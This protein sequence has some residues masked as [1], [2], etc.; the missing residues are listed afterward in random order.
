M[1]ER[2]SKANLGLERSSSR[3]VIPPLREPLSEITRI[4]ESHPDKHSPA[5]TR[6]RNR[7]VSV[8]QLRR[9]SHHHYTQ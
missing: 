6:H 9:R 4:G 3:L 1:Q 2:R 7:F 8:G 5:A